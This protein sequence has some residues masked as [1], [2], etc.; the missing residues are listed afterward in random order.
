MPV[1][2]N[3]MLVPADQVGE[4]MLGALLRPLGGAAAGARHRATGSPSPWNLPV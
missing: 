3:L 2:E 4:R 1:I